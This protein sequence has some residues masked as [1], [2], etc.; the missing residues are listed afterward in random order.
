[1]KKVGIIF[2]GMSSEHDVSV[3]SGN[4]VLK[5]INKEKYEIYPIY[6]SKDGNWYEYEETKDEIEIGYEV[7]KKK[8]IENILKYLQ[9]LDIVFP[10]LHGAYGEDGTIQGLL[11]CMKVPYVGCKV[12]ASSI[13]M[14]KAYT[15]ILFEKAGLKQVKYCYIKKYNNKYIFVNK[16]LDEEIMGI[17][18]ITNKIQGNIKYPMFVKPSRAGSSV[19]INKAKNSI[20]LKKAIEYAEKFDKKIIIEEGIKAR[21]IEC[22]VL[23]NEE[24]LSSGTGEIIPADEFYSY[25]AKYKN[26]QSRTIVPSGIKQEEEVKK[27]AVKA[28]KAIDGT[29]LARVDFFL[30]DEGDIYIN[31]INT[32]PGF[33]SISMYSKLWEQAGLD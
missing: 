17:D 28:F 5:H 16:N 33:T 13:G 18:D 1:M 20:E 19:G 22:A 15:K 7:Q 12:L 2:G 27:L 31:E 32:M 23:G 9:N 3:V 29:G 14:D 4:S 10:V 30:T 11:E 6:I 21:E 25:D 24:A 8:L 26:A